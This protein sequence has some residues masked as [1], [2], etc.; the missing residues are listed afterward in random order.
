MAQSTNTELPLGSDAPTREDELPEPL[1]FTLVVVSPSV[2]ITGPLTFPQLLATTSVK[3]LKGKIRDA[4]P[5]KPA[6]ENQ[7]LIHRGRM[8]A[9]EAETMEDIFGKDT[10]ANPESQTLHLVLRPTGPDLPSNPPSVTHP[11]PQRAPTPSQPSLQPPL[12]AR[13]QSTPTIPNYGVPGQQNLPGIQHIHQHQLLHQAD[14]VQNVASQHRLQQLQMEFARLQQEMMSIEQRSRALTAGVPAILNGNMPAGQFQLQQTGFQQPQ[15]TP[16]TIQQ[17]IQQQQLNRANAGR[18]GAQDSLGVNP[19]GPSASGRAS[20]TA[21]RPDHTTTTTREGIGPNGERWQITV[22]ET[23]TSYPISQTHRHNLNPQ[24]ASLENLHNLLRH[25]DRV[26]AAFP[27]L[28]NNLERSANNVEA[29]AT[30]TSVSNN[31]PS[32]Q[33][34]QTQ[35][36]S[37]SS[38]EAA[39]PATTNSSPSSS[40]LLNQ[41]LTTHPPV[42]TTAASNNPSE[43]TNPVVYLLSSPQGPRALLLNGAE[44]FYSPRPSRRRGIFP[45]SPAPAQPRGQS[46]P[47]LNRRPMRANRRDA[48]NGENAGE[49][50][51]ILNGH[52]AHGN[53]AAGALGA[54]IG[55]VIW[56]IIRLA[57]FVW[58]FTAGSTG[59]WRFLMVSGLAVVLFIVNTGILNGVAEQLWGPV[60]RH[61]E[62]LIPLAGPEAAMVPARNA[63]I[64]QQGAVVQGGEQPPRRRRRGE[65]DEREVATR[66]IE[67]RRQA[68]AGW[69]MAQIR[70]AEHAALLFVASFVPGVGERHIAAREAEAAEAEAER[71][72]QIEAAAATEQTTEAGEGRESGEVQEKRPDSPSR[73]EVGE[74]APPAAEA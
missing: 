55:Q 37:D 10:L 70:R 12:Q 69:V 6:D 52:A 30:T 71:Q 68:N 16:L 29:A 67:Q 32:A 5:S 8:L 17:L 42:V 72:R 43:N 49:A 18:L 74:R 1:K 27:T 39:T 58:F 56:L 53:P 14:L 13:P 51:P 23:T 47:P 3:D 63:V 19:A 22:N 59:W 20:P 2:G 7:R 46:L 9:R 15:N 26:S 54:R 31:V 50:E 33:S 25:A 65:L 66:L 44:T 62:N 4:L 64:P 35:I 11:G 24:Q 41:P 28:P 60:R 40:V 36:H 21:H 73:T 38:P 57:G 61:V 48:A 34:Q 45:T